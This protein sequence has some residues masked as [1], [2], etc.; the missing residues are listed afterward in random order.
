M[1]CRDAW[2]CCRFDDD[3]E[4]APPT[5]ADSEKK[6]LR[7]AEQKRADVAEARCLWQEMQAKMDVTNLILLDETWT[8]TNMTRRYGRCPRDTP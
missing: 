2:G 5:R 8:K 6:S 7:A 1:A 4:D 3:L